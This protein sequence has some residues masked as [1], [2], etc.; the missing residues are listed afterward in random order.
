MLDKLTKVWY[1]VIKSE[2]RLVSVS[3]PSNHAK[4]GTL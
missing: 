1:N 4:G 3:L 2:G